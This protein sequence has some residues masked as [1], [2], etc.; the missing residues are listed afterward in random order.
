MTPLRFA[1]ELTSLKTIIV[2]VAL[3]NGEGN[4][5]S[6]YNYYLMRI[7]QMKSIYAG[8]VVCVSVAVAFAVRVQAYTDYPLYVVNVADNGETCTALA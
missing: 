2:A 5:Y 7:V 8:A 3:D 4:W 6:L 1:A